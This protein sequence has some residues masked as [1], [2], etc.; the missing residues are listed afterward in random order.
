V[1]RYDD[2]KA[3]LKAA[4]RGDI[5]ANLPIIQP[6]TGARIRYGGNVKNINSY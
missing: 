5:T 4:G 3:W 1:K 6:T 2:A